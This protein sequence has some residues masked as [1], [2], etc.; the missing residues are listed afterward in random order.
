MQDPDCEELPKKKSLLDDIFDDEII[1]GK[2]EP[3]LPPLERA[4]MEIIAY[5]QLPGE[6]MK[7]KPL[8]FWKEKADDFPLLASLAGLYLCVQASSVA[9]ERM[10]SSA[11]DIVTATR[12][13]LDPE[14]VDRL[15]F[16]K[17]NMS[18]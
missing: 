8:H 3:P 17:K 13:C 12:A 10:F 18:K 11:G 1:I 9:S 5:R 7:R 4:K 2:E 6:N 16:L 15:I 14:N